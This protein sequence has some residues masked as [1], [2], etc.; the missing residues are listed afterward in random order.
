MVKAP[1]LSAASQQQQ[2][3]A[4]CPKEIIHQPLA[5]LGGS[6][7]QAVLIHHH[8]HQPLQH[9]QHPAPQPQP[10]FS[11]PPPLAGTTTTA[12]YPIVSN[13]SGAVTVK[14]QHRRSAAPG[15]QM[16]GGG[17]PPGGGG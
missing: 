14:N 3:K 9:P 5:T 13:V 2:Q 1:V 10:L 17:E 12:Y 15:V 6:P 8:T 11:Y 7:A 16:S 4:Q